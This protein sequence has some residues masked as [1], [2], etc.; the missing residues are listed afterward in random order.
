MKTPDERFADFGRKMQQ[1]KHP[2]QP[3]PGQTPEAYGRAVAR[4]V[5][6]TI[7]NYPCCGK[8]ASARI[9]DDGLVAI[10]PQYHD[11]FEYDYLE[12]AYRIEIGIP[13]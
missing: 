4:Q 9:D 11:A 8:R 13:E 7:C 6:I 5:A 12:A 3:Q 2:L 1:I 10:G